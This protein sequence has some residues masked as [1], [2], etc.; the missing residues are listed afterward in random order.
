MSPTKVGE[1]LAAGLPVVSGPGVG[2]LDELLDDRRV[3]V[4]VEGFSEPV[5]ERVAARVRELVADPASRARCREVARGVYSLEEV[6]IPRY[7]RIYR[8]L[9]QPSGDGRS[10][11]R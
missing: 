11:V 6:G 2:D 4:V 3:G 10:G 7:D 5:Y 1:Y 9:A 8:R